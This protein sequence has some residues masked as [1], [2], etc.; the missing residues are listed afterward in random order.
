[1]ASAKKETN[2]VARGRNWAFIVYPDSAPE[3]WRTLVSDLHIPALLSPLHK[4]INP[5]ETEKK[6]HW[7][8]LVMFEGNKSIEQMQEI[9]DML[10]SP[11]P[12]RVDSLRGYARYLIH[13]DNP[14]K[15]QYN[16]MDVV[17]FGGADYH[18]IA[19]LANDKYEAIAEMISWCLRYQIYS[20]AT[21]LTYAMN[22]NIGWY[23]CLC[24]NGTR[25]MK[26]FLQTK[27][28]ELK[29]GLEAYSDMDKLYE[30]IRL[31]DK[32]EAEKEAFES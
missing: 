22:N 26:E 12:Q 21:L 19:N 20:Y 8:L 5:D 14:E 2:K 6:Q 31:V 24:D 3:N 25:V 9:A 28:W 15:V 7:H 27:Y 4:D 29:E 16:A 1:M 18:I 32:L 30:H 23:R 13:A 10:N 17:S 11:R